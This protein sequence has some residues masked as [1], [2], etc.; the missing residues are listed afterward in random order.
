MFITKP[1]LKMR[2]VVVALRVLLRMEI[3]RKS[4]SMKRRLLLKSKVPS[5]LLTITLVLRMKPRIKRVMKVMRVRLKLLLALSQTPVMTT[6]KR[7]W[8]C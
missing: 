7:V 4:M 6:T 5:K 1:I 3:V 8:G 2:R